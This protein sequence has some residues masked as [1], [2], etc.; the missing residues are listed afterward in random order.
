MAGGMA[1]ATKGTRAAGGELEA[2]RD[3][4]GGLGRA[5]LAGGLG[6]GREASANV[7]SVESQWRRRESRG[8][9]RR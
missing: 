1:G 8:Q 4:L 6:G 2:A 5:E 3:G 9:R 7:G